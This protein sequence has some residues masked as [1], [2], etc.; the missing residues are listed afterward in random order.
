MSLLFRRLVGRLQV[1]A[2]FVLALAVTGAAQP[3]SEVNKYIAFLDHMKKNF[4]AYHYDAV[5]GECTEM[6]RLHPRFAEAFYFRGQAYELKLDD[7]H[8]LTDFNTAIALAPEY[9]E[10]LF[11]RSTIYARRGNHAKAIEDA[12]RAI[13]G[14]PI[15]TDLFQLADA[16]LIRGRSYYVAGDY[17]HAIQDLTE[18]IR[19]QPK[20]ALTHQ[21]FYYR[22]RAYT[23]KQD[24]T[25][26]AEDYKKALELKPD[27]TEARVALQA[28]TRSQDAR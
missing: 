28:A 19:L 20:G 5:I 16:L 17:D 8:A 11:S 26:A 2:L 1:C 13:A 15:L 23:D 18:A 24:Q 25:R 12:T 4:K 3:Q 9:A 27:F 10:A 22:G 21:A 14:K 7:D 6:I